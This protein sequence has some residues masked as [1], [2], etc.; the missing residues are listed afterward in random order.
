MAGLVFF[1]FIHTVVRGL[2]WKSNLS[3]FS[4]AVEV[5]PNNPCAPLAPAKE[6]N[7]LKF[8]VARQGLL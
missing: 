1:F 5:A 6:K 7:A 2:D 4:F 8:C 3:L